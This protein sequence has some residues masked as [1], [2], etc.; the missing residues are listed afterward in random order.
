[1]LC[2]KDKTFCKHYDCD[3]FKKCDRSL[4]EKVIKDAQSWWG[5]DNPPISVF[6]NKPECFVCKSCIK[7]ECQNLEKN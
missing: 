2:Y 6:E 1:M 7:S 5:G 3:L 4:T